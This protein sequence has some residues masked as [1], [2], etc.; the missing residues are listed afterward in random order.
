MQPTNL[1]EVIQYIAKQQQETLA[2][3]ITEVQTKLVTV[4]YDKAAAYTTVI[5]FGGYAGFFAIWQLAKDHL[6]KDQALWS[7]LLILISLLTFVLFEL[8]KMVLVSRT[9]IRKMAVLQAPEVRHDPQRLLQA[10]QELEG[11]QQPSVR[12]FL[13]FWVF[14]L[15]V[16]VGCALGGASVLGYAFIT[17]L[18]K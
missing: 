9:L 13:R 2:A 10:L 14:V 11:K 12:L 5:V 8:T 3:Q 18:A 16:A 15:V 7:A 4:S 6:S 17:G 1:A